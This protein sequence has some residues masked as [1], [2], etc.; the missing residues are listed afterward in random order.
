MMKLPVDIFSTSTK[1]PGSENSRRLS[2]LTAFYSD[3][4]SLL[5]LKKAG[6]CLRVARNTFSLS[7]KNHGT[8]VPT[9]IRLRR[10]DVQQKTCA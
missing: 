6:L 3:P 2:R 9:L 8:D 5:A 4:A 10:G 7:S 1:S